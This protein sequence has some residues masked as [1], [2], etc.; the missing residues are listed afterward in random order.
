MILSTQCPLCHHSQVETYHQDAHRPY[1]QCRCCALIFVPPAYR[2]TSAAEKEVYDQHNNDPTDAGYRRF[3]FRLFAPIRER[4]P[5][6]AQGLDFGS[7]PGPTLS[8]MFAEAGYTMAIYDPYYAADTGVLTKSY[9]FITASEVAEHLYQPGEVLAQLYCLLR[10]GGWLGLMTKLVS[11]RA[12]FARW[13]YTRDLTHVCFFSH[14]TLRW[15]AKQF[16]CPIFFIGQ[17]VILLH[18]ERKQ[19]RSHLPS[20][21]RC[22]LYSRTNSTGS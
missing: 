19:Q 21:K 20:Q 10:P 13:H 5:P 3:L 17:D 6:P 11:N 16:C 15:W 2:L 22:R 7:G 8:T 9:D 1:Y 4:L 14:Q 12:A 18:K